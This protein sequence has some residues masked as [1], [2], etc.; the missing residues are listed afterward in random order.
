MDELNRAHKSLRLRFKEASAEVDCDIRR[1]ENLT[2][3]L[4]KVFNEFV[5]CFNQFVQREERLE[6]LHTQAIRKSKEL[7]KKMQ[8]EVMAQSSQRSQLLAIVDDLTAQLK[9]TKA[10]T[11]ATRSLKNEHAAH[12]ATRQFLAEVEKQN[13][14]MKKEIH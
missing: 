13:A 4:Q 10:T 2:E 6:T 5:A 3:S 1:I 11:V 7:S 12:E 8:L 14:A 9:E